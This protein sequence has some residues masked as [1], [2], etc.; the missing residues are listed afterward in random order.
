MPGND[1]AASRGPFSVRVGIKTPSATEN[2]SCG[3]LAL[4]RESFR[5]FLFSVRQKSMRKA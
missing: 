3:D 2:R 1:V 5:Q 4:F